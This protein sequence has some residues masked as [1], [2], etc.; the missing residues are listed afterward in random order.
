M[1]PVVSMPVGSIPGSGRCATNARPASSLGTSTASSRYSLQNVFRKICGWR[2]ISSSGNAIGDRLVF[3]R[4]LVDTVEGQWLAVPWVDKKKRM[5]RFLLPFHL[6][7]MLFTHVEIMPSHS[8]SSCFYGHER[9]LCKIAEA[10]RRERCRRSVRLV[11]DVRLRQHCTDGRGPF[12]DRR[13]IEPESRGL[14]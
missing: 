11:A 2:P 1:F 9:L 13:R 8:F 12:F 3:G 14:R 10:S 6:S 5:G 4:H 7:S